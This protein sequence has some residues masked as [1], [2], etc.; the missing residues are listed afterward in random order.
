MKN[1]KRLLSL[2]VLFVMALV[3][4]NP[5]SVSAASN[6]SITINKAIVGETYRIYKVLKLETYDATYNH[7]IYRATEEF[8]PFIESA[9]GQKYLTAQNG[10]NTGDTFYV[11]NGENTDSRVQEFAKLAMKYAED[12]T[13]RATDFKVAD[14]TTV[15]F[16]G[17]DLGYYLVSSTTITDGTKLLSLTTT[18]PS[19]TTNEK[20]TKK[21]D[22]D[23]KVLEG[24]VYGTVSDASIGDTVQF[25]ATVITGAGYEKYVLCDKM[26]VGLTFNSG[27]VVVKIGD[28]V[29]DS[30]N[31]AV[32]E[33]VQDYTFTVA[34]KDE[35]IAKQPLNTNI[36]VYYTAVL[37]EN[38]V[39]E[40]NG[41][42]NK[43]QLKYGENHETAKK[44]TV[45]YTY[46]FDLVKTDKKMN[47]LDGAEFKLY[48]ANGNEIAVVLDENATTP[49]TYRVAVTGETGVLIKAGKAT[50]NGLD[51]GNYQLEE[52]T[53]PTGYNKL[54]SK[55][56][57][58]ITGKD[59]NTTYARGSVDVINYTG[60]ELP[61]TGGFGTTLFVT[62][63]SLLVIGF[64]LLLVTKL[65]V[66]KENL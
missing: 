33:N 15:S 21:P 44:Q 46:A 56:N 50:I 3:Q 58:T 9:D 38:A 39:I 27:S 61:E 19:A 31:Y 8:K 54:T 7:Y 48:D 57:F 52:I 6:G 16:T 40:G 47:P 45:T 17:L 66:Y 49:N 24:G 1:I 60:S 25:K 10:N 26:D 41:N 65:R 22:V 12:H 34:F 32:S 18:K 64:G 4:M 43:N 35:F 62:F 2:A 20:N 59:A 55:V 36:D 37:N 42:L 28:T 11:W 29:V 30:S 53:A 23:K 13:I 14:T 51:K 5:L 63:G